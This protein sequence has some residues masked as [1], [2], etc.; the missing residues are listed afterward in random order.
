MRPTLIVGIGLNSKATNDEVKA[1]MHSGLLSIGAAIGDVAAIATAEH[2][3]GH[4]GLLGIDLPIRYLPDHLF[5]PRSVAETAA[6]HASSS[7][8]LVLRKHCTPNVC[9]A[10]AAINQFRERF[11]PL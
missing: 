4:P 8:E 9:I 6:L 3:R 11:S 2:R 5:A 10:I 1:A 7:D